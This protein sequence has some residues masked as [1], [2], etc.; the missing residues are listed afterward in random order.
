MGK[1]KDGL[2]FSLAMAP[3]SIAAG[4]CLC[5]YQ[6]DLYPEEE[7]ALIVE[8]AGSRGALV[9][10][11]VGQTL[12]AVMLASFFGYLLSNAVGL[13]H[14]R[15]LEPS[16]VVRCLL[17]SAAAGVLFSLDFWVFGSVLEEVRDSI[18]PGLTV[19]GVAAAVLYGGVVEEILM[20]LFFMS[21]MVFLLWKLFFH[22]RDRQH[23]PEG[24]FITANC[25]AALVFALGH[26]P[27]TML[28]FGK[29]TPLV[30]FRCLLLNGGFG[31]LFGRIYRKCGLR[32]AM[33]SHAT[34]HLVSK[35]IWGLLL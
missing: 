30:V 5:I 33:L 14:A 13:W 2:K 7:L 18:I 16:A 22:R 8:Q 6:L 32:C 27:A 19:G 3:V 11:G 35:L 12:A 34:L 28:L 25:L 20:R 1:M 17:V 21:L 4:L 31:L 23:I 29:L 9:L 26:L 24:V 10:I 15:V